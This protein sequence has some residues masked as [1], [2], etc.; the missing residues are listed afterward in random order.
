MDGRDSDESNRPSPV[1]EA[2]SNTGETDDDEKVLRRAGEAMDLVGLC[3]RIGWTFRNPVLLVRS[4]AHRSWC[5]ENDAHSN[6][7]LE[8]LG[9][10]VLGL[11]VTSHI[12]RTF[13]DLPEG[14]LAKL[15]ASVVNSAV[16]AELAESLQLGSVILLGK[17][18]AATGGRR[19]SSILADA[20]EALIG[21]VYL[22]GGWLPAEQLVLRILSDR[23][24]EY[25]EGPG[26]SDYKTRLQELAA[27]R[28]EALPV[29]RVS[30]AGPD[31]AKVFRAE[32]SLSGRLLGVGEGRSKKQGEQ[33][34]AEQAWHLLQA[35]IAASD[36]VADNV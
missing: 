3:E 36:Q 10:S 13:P 2:H 8:F 9:D 12:F 31:H 6:E 19:K 1:D 28:F 33:A 30:G 35:E 11:V 29:Y 22:D 17:G 32:V 21:A 20:L 5:G 24:A 34:A 16:L 14:D 15:R 23:I 7:R 27:R 26:G 25:A 4:L 18:E